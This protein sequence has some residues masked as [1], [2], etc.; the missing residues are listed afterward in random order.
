MTTSKA[1][2]LDAMIEV[3]KETG[4]PVVPSV[5]QQ[6]PESN[7]PLTGFKS[8]R[9]NGVEMFRIDCRWFYMNRVVE[10]A[11]STGERFPK[12]LIQALIEAFNFQNSKNP[13]GHLIAYPGDGV[14]E[15]RSAMLV[16]DDTLEKPQFRLLLD[17]FM[18]DGE[19]LFDIRSLFSS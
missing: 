17:N 14:I 1:T 8:W 13:S 7:S 2:I 16:V 11:M 18:E 4:L 19:I 10:L 12:G 15:Y 9:S 6:F 5:K 3:F